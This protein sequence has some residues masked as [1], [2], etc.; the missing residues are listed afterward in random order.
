MQG[1]G[2]RVVL[3]ILLEKRQN[4]KSG[5]TLPSLSFLGDTK[6]HE[7]S[8]VFTCPKQFITAKFHNEKK[9]HYTRNAQSHSTITRQ[10]SVFASDT[11]YTNSWA[12]NKRQT[13]AH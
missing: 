12:S 11:K 1:Q 3:S 5:R 2:N 13:Q 9:E 6:T 10:R 7:H 4:E 8:P